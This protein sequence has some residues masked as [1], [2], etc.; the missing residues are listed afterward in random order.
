LSAKP[1]RIETAGVRPEDG[2][3][4]WRGK[5]QAGIDGNG[6]QGGNMHGSWCFRRGA[7]FAAALALSL[8]PSS[9][10][11]EGASPELRYNYA[12]R[13][14]LRAAP[15]ADA[16]ALALLPINQPLLLVSRRERWCEVRVPETK[17]TG[18][19]DCAYL[20]PGMLDAAAIEAEVARLLREL[21]KTPPPEEEMRKLNQLFRLIDRHFALS[22]S[23]YVCNDYSLL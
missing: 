1:G 12:S 22:P 8:A 4:T 16:A 19:V 2:A 20:G 18:F 23:L 10:Q 14:T 21:R 3:G 5:V 6:K 9:A 13:L 11:A 7:L 15:A 17:Q